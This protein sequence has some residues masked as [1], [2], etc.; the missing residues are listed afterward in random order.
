MVMMALYLACLPDD[1]A[2][3]LC[4]LLGDGCLHYHC[5]AVIIKR[6]HTSTSIISGKTTFVKR[7]LTGEFEKKYERTN[8]AGAAWL[9][10]VDALHVAPTDLH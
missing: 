3:S 2:A 6:M 10:G 9:F 8:A 4:I 1:G 5:T 7:H